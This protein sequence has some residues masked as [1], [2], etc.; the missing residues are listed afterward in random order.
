MVLELGMLESPVV[1]LTLSFAFAR[2]QR[3]CLEKL[4]LWQA[5]TFAVI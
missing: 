3:E 4:N 2:V 1:D 5:I